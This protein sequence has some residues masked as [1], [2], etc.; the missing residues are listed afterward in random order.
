MK[1]NKKEKRV[2]HHQQNHQNYQVQVGGRVALVQ[3]EKLTI[4]IT[5]STTQTNNQTIIIDSNKDIIKSNYVAYPPGL[6]EIRI[7]I[8]MATNIQL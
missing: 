2:Q 5:T 1:K 3:L 8:K 7:R 4:A 6:P